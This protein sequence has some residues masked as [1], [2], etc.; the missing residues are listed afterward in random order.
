[1]LNNTF[2]G[3]FQVFGLDKNGVGFSMDEF[4]EAL[5]PV[6]LRAKVDESKARIISGDIK[7]TDAMSGN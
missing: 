4:N 5:V 3:G 6:A 7:V 1:V 2:R